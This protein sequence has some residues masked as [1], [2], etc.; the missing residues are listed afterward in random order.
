MGFMY[1]LVFVGVMTLAS[2]LS[3]NAVAQGKAAP[4]WVL[5][6][7]DGQPVKLSDYRGQV[8]MLN[9]WASWCKPCREEMPLLD[10]LQRRYSAI[11]FTV[12]GVNVDQNSTNGKKMLKNSP[13][14]FPVVF[15]KENTTLEQ[16][17]VEAMPS[18]YMIDRKGNIRYVHRG[19]KRGDDAKYN[20]YIRKL[21]RE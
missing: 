19:Y 13:V 8:V 12:V 18:T 20:N 15:D 4:Q 9:F 1:R 17:G 16:Y 6:G 3:V 14:G 11:G 21:L 5:P 7:I 2:L 10:A